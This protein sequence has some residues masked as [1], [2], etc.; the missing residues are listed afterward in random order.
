MLI[1]DLGLHENSKMFS[2]PL[3]IKQ[4]KDGPAAPCISWQAQAQARATVLRLASRRRFG[5]KK[6]MQKFPVQEPPT[7][8]TKSHYKNFRSYSCILIWLCVNVFA[9]PPITAAGC[10]REDLTQ[11]L[12]LLFPR[13]TTKPFGLGA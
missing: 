5:K 9:L 10:T 6:I 1:G 11:S 2:H 7:K 12:G 13:N 8:S 3:T 4:L